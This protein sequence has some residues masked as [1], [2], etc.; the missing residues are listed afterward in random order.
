ME[1]TLTDF[2]STVYN[3]K[4]I[5]TDRLHVAILSKILDKKATL[6]GN[7]YHKNKGVWEHS[8][9]EDVEFIET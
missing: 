7:K 8:L 9:R 5:Y 1:K 4:N 3:A 2:V 6:F